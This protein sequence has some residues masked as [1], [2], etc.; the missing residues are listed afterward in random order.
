MQTAKWD[1][2]IA[3]PEQDGD[4]WRIG[5]TLISPIAG[6]PSERIAIDERFHSAHGAIAEATRLA[7]LES[8]SAAVARADEPAVSLDPTGAEIKT[9]FV[10]RCPANP[11]PTRDTKLTVSYDF[12]FITPVFL[13]LGFGGSDGVLTVSGTSVMP[14]LR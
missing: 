9:T 12:E 6:V 4:E 5:Y 7:A 14:C 11:D 10:E 13:A 8:D 3:Q 1:F 2:Q